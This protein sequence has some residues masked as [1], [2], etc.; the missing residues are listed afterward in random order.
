MLNFTHADDVNLCHV[1][2][3]KKSEEI[4]KK[5]CTEKSKLETMILEFYENDKENMGTDETILKQSNIVDQ[6]VI[7]EIFLSEMRKKFFEYEKQHNG[8]L[9]AIK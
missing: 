1:I 4:R 9:E 7:D 5:L 8:D 6:L 3:R 2:L